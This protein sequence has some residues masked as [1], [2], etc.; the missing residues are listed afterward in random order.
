MTGSKELRMN[1]REATLTDIERIQ[2]IRNAVREN[3][4]SD[5]SLVPDSD[6]QDYITRRG[7]GWVSEAA[8]M[9]TGFAIVSLLDKNV[10]ALFA[11][12]QFEGNGVGRMLHDRMLDW[13]FEQTNETLWLSTAPGTRAE[14]FYRKAGWKETGLY[15]KGEIR[16]EMDCM[17]WS[18]TRNTGK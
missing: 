2:E 5:P 3:R 18:T 10:W 15:G 9:I 12:P 6:V 1:I 14:K 13:Y 8:G 4:L 7:K 16:F 17:N 11:D